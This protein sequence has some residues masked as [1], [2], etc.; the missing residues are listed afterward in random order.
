MS[1]ENA[2]IPEE[3]QQPMAEEEEEEEKQQLLSQVASLEEEQQ[4]LQ[5]QVAS[6]QEEQQQLQSQIVNL[7]EV[8]AI[9]QLVG[10]GQV[11]SAILAVSQSQFVKT[12]IQLRQEEER[13]TEV[14]HLNQ[15]DLL[16]I[17]T[18]ISTIVAYLSSIN[19]T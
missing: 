9:T 16:A 6:L 5:S 12:L 1:E 18:K 4:Q 3:E 10:Q 15:Q 14:V 2:P 13:M 7:D 11:G 8:A 17:Q 19:T